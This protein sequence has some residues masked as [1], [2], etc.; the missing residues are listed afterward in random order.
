MSIPQRLDRLTPLHYLI[1]I[2]AIQTTHLTV[3]PRK[4]RRS[5]R[6]TPNPARS[7]SFHTPTHPSRQ[8]PKLSPSPGQRPT[9]ESSINRIGAI[10]C[11]SQ[12]TMIETARHQPA[13]NNDPYQDF[14]TGSPSGQPRTR[15]LGTHASPRRVAPTEIAHVGIVQGTRGVDI[16]V[17]RPG[18]GTNPIRNGGEPIP[19][20][21]DSSLAFKKCKKQTHLLPPTLTTAPNQHKFKSLVVTS[22]TPSSNRV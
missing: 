3:P 10:T 4:R 22:A 9:S 14:A 21:A 13:P 1:C 18:H 5:R 11:H 12:A 15:V 20:G 17:F 16:E 2:Q 19:S 6:R 7:R 8:K